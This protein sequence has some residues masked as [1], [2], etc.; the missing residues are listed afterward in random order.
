MKETKQTASSVPVGNE[1]SNGRHEVRLVVNEDKLTE[2]DRWS[3][4]SETET[5]SPIAELTLQLQRR[6]IKSR[7]SVLFGQTLRRK[8]G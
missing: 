8:L 4:V 5:F 3:K 2:R 1:N 7:Q 6:F